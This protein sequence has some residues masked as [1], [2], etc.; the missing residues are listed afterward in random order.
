LKAEGRVGLDRVVAKRKAQS[1][2]CKVGEGGLLC[3]RDNM[4]TNKTNQRTRK[5]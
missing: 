3:I 4:R 1:A 5:S 2:K